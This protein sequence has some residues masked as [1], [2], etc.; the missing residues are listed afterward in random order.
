MAK[1]CGIQSFME[2]VEFRRFLEGDMICVF[3]E[4]RRVHS[5]HGG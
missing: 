4:E 5:I 3:R 1:W 2:K